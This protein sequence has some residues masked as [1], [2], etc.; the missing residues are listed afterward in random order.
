MDKAKV[1]QK[2]VDHVGGPDYVEIGVDLGENIFRIKAKNKIGVDPY[3]KYKAKHLRISTSDEFFGSNPYIDGVIFIDGLHTYDQSLRDAIN[4]IECSS[5]RSIIL[6][7]DS[8]PT[9]PSEATPNVPDPLGSWM[10]EV[11][12]SVAHLRS[13]REDLEIYTLDMP[14][15]LTVIGKHP[16]NTLLKINPNK[17]KDLDFFFFLMNK[18]EIL[19]LKSVTLEEN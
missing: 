8:I 2:F 18:D 12:K 16:S 9:M 3:P 10:G 5:D 15:G 14:C 17:I 7:H 11:W 6:M 4:S 13:T 19:N 1:I